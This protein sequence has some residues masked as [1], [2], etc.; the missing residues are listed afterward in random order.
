MPVIHGGNPKKGV[1]FL[2]ATAREPRAYEIMAVFLPELAD[3]E[4]TAQ[5]DRTT[6][7]ITSVGGT[8]KEVLTDSP[9]GRRRLAY[10]IRFNSQDFRDGYYAVYH[11]DL[12]PSAMIDIERE[13]KL[14]T[15]VMR[16][17]VVHDDPK[18]GERNTGR[19]AEETSSGDA[20]VTPAASTDVSAA[21]SDD[22]TSSAPEGLALATPVP[23]EAPAELASEAPETAPVQQDTTQAAPAAD[24]AQDAPSA[25]ESAPPA[26]GNPQDIAAPS[27]T[28]APDPASE[29][30]PA[31]ETAPG[32]ASASPE[33]DSEE[34]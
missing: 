27:T 33:T 3:E 30:T 10:P 8:I 12:V 15:R 13:L 29:Q 17:L 24:V 26:E 28:P 19:P 14:D 16:Y 34:D 5:L 21:A 23:D 7:Y 20:E 2:V 25:V 31:E 18:A 22:A 1:S 32:T 4:L 6:S 11:F 9:W